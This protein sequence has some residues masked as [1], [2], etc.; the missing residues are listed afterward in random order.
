MNEKEAG[1]R[2][3]SHEDKS[4]EANPHRYGSAEH[5]AWDHGYCGAFL[6]EYGTGLQEYNKFWSSK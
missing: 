1:A 6:R 2:A 3:F 4:R 5:L